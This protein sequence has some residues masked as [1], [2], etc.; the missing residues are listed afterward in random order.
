M[1]NY[2]KHQEW[3]IIEEGFDP[4]MNK[5]SESI[6]SIGNGRMGQRA[7]FEETY[8]GETLQGNYV[9]GVYYPDKT[10]VGWWKN[11]YPE[12]FAKVLNAT[13]WIGIR[14]AVNGEELDLNTAKVLEFS[15]VLDMQ[16]GTLTRKFIVEL[17]SGNVLGVEAVRF[18]SLVDDV[19]G[20]ICYSITPHN[21]DGQLSIESSLD[22]DVKNQDSNYD[23][24]FWTEISKT[25]H[26]S[27]ALLTME[28]KKTAFWVS[29]GMY[30]EIHQDG[31]KLNLEP[32][33][34]SKEKYVAQQFTLDVKK[35]QT[36][37]IYKYA[38]NL[39]S[40]NYA[41][42]NIE[43]EA[44]AT[45]Q[46]IVAKGFDQ[47][48]QEQAQAWAG[49][50][51]N[52]D[53]VIEGDVAAQQAIRFNIFQLHQT[54][55]GE[56]ARLNIGPKGFTGEKYGGSTYWD[57][58]AYCLPFYL[59]T[60][61]QQ[62]AENLLIYRYKQLDKAIENAEKL[63]FKNGA[64]LYP[65]V[66]MNGEE[67]HNEWEITFEEIHRNG[68]IAFAIFNYIRYTGDQAYL[69]KYGLEVLIGIARFWAQR[70]NWSIEKERYV[71]LGVTGP[72][73]YENNVNNNWYTST[74][75]T[76]CLKYT[77]Q[78]IDLVR[79]MDAVRLTELFAKTN[80]GEQEE[81]GHWQ[82][83]I[84]KMFYPADEK[85]G[86]FLQQDGYLDKEQILVKDLPAADRP[87][88]QKWSWDRILRSCFIKQADVLQGIYF[89]EEDYDLETIRR[90]Y[91][92]Y[93]PRT[94]HESSLSP[95]VHAIIA[96]K[97]GDLDRAYEFYLRTSRLDLDD[98]NND[99][100]D[101]LHITSMAGTW[102]SVVEGFGGMRIK[103]GALQL[104][105]ILPQKWTSYAFK[106][107]FRQALVTVKVSDKQ[108]KLSNESNV[109]LEIHVF[110]Q[111]NLLKANSNL[112]LNT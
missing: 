12:Y 49:K 29:S 64:A 37:S 103:E 3:Q 76:W 62:V 6:F 89:F 58:E 47:M 94:V 35:A 85:L 97:L 23:E 10:R 68:A 109:D 95:C 74:I 40:E 80:F 56:D 32:K 87:L 81:T 21:F 17:R 55:T 86:I 75:A 98:Y 66:T 99:T 9:A 7:N 41:K 63:G 90:N 50:W 5:I 33:F 54:Y 24:K 110:G 13:N 18:C 96:A 27:F 36:T 25:E 26:D 11:G 53:V 2:I 59:A 44:V 42:S 102:L 108:V 70:V 84:D 1:K 83:I 73:E 71:M 72:N 16:L 15:R 60:A 65:M 8:T 52:G 57:T 92:F 30:T 112:E 82:E 34:T 93:E 111:A 48:R 28:T 45:L 20:A 69:A 77:I 91:D 105:P 67:C 78:A 46:K 104:H 79:N 43:S 39:S 22:G 19:A 107:G 14:I 88:N 51:Q 61:P 100:E 101:G 31:V 106:I 38:V 4:H